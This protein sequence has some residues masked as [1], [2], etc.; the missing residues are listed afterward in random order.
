M[1]YTTNYH[2]PQWEKSDRIQMEDFNSA[3]Q[4]VDETFPQVFLGTYTGNGAYGS[5]SPTGLTFPFQ[6][7]FIA[8]FSP[9]GVY[10]LLCARGAAKVNTSPNGHS[11]GALA[12][13]WGENSVAWHTTSSGS[14]ANYQMN[15]ADSVYSYLVIGR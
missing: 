15:K 9:D 11:Y 12:V 2:L 1:N 7:W 4:I 5:G 14:D 13:T 3:F 10:R 6:P 8:I